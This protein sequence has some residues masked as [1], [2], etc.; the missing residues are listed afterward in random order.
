M[1]GSS[2]K[3]KFGLF[4]V[5]AAALV[6]FAGTATTAKADVV[7][8]VNG[9][10]EDGGTLSGT[11]TIDV[12]GFLSDWDLKTQSVG[13]FGGF[14]YLP[15]NSYVS[16]GALYA[17][18]QPGY[19]RDLHLAFASDLG[20]AAANNPILGGP[21]GPSYECVGSY[22]CYIPAGGATRYLFEGAAVAAVPEAST[23]AMMILGF[24]GVGFMAYRRKGR[25]ALRLA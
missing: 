1:K 22:S 23:W 13:P 4:G 2:R 17:D 20:V 8:T 16:N 7:W 25:P 14:Q 9:T 5:L 6:L 21:L 19:V 11:F 12:Y 3:R 18:F 24:A 10:F 15:G